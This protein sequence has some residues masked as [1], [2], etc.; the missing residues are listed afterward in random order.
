MYIFAICIYP[1]LFFLGMAF[2][3]SWAVLSLLVS[4][5]LPTDLSAYDPSLLHQIA[6]QP[7]VYTVIQQ[8]STSLYTYACLLRHALVFIPRALMISCLVVPFAV[9]VRC[10]M[11]MS[12]AH[13]LCLGPPNPTE[14]LSSPYAYILAFSLSVEALILF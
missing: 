8:C 9:C 7:Y 14:L 13:C 11:W 1:L 6:A 2:F 10:L 5:I 4:H 3:C 12:Y